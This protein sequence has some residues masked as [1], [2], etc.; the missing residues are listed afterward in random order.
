MPALA[1]VG[2]PRRPSASLGRTG[3][4]LCFRT[5]PVNRTALGITHPMSL[6]LIGAA[7]AFG[8]TS[9]TNAEGDTQSAH[10]QAASTQTVVAAAAHSTAQVTPEEQKLYRDAAK[11]AWTYMAA[12]YQ[13]STGFV[14]ATADWANTT[15]WDVGGQILAFRAAKGIG[16]ISAADYDAKTKKLLAT[17]Q[18]VPL[19]RKA[20]FNKVYDSKTG[21]IGAGGSHGFAA[22]D[23]GRL[24]VAL[25]ILKETEPQY[26]AQI[27]RIVAR[28]DFHQVVKNGYLYGQLLG[29]T[30]KPV[31]FQEGRIGY[32]QY[33]ARGFSEW[34]ADVGNA[35]DLKKNSTPVTV[36]GVP[37]LKDT[38][39]QDRLL[40]E[41]FVLY[42]LELGMPA[43]L[44]QLASS[45]LAAQKARFDS[46]GKIT[47]VS[48]DASTI[49]PYYFYYYCVYCNAKPFVI[50]VAEPGKELDSPRWVSTKAAFGWNALMPSDYTKKA[51]D[52]LTPAMDARRGWASGV[53]ESAATSTNTWDINTASVVLEAAFYTLRGR[54]PLI[55]KTAVVLP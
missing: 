4:A 41:P 31:S 27:A 36:Y 25:K 17:L 14:N 11:V 15:M 30:G 55:D 38:R 18:R 42:G 48:E 1:A 35:M 19:F 12:N 44:D 39:Y 8:A 46:T 32:E 50:D 10:P 40:S 51:V 23:L 21:G 13:K 26:A 29:S 6:I 20:A 22:T 9:C 7:L 24:L 5:A 45:V 52:Y 33:I 47:I 2:S 43:D 16:L 37:L 34:G 3:P 28:I 54:K 53:M 49:A